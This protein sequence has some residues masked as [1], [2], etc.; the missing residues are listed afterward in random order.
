[1]ASKH[2][3][4]RGVRHSRVTRLRGHEGKSKRAP[5]GEGKTPKGPTETRLQRLWQSLGAFYG[6][7]RKLGAGDESRTASMAAE[8][9]TALS[10]LL[11]R[12]ERERE[13]LPLSRERASRGHRVELLQERLARAEAERDFEEW[14]RVRDEIEQLEGRQAV[15]MMGDRVLRDLRNEVRLGRV[16]G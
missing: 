2:E 15:E 11:R 4:K 16:D 13:G 14:V 3:G 6:A 1:M 12:F 5:R 10:G 9:E 7:V 8:T